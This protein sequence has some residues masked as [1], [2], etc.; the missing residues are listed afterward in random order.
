MADIPTLQ[1]TLD[2]LRTAHEQSQKELKLDERLERLE[3]QRREFEKQ[4]RLLEEQKKQNDRMI[5]ET[6]RQKEGSGIRQLNEFLQNNVPTE[7]SLIGIVTDAIQ[8]LCPQLQEKLPVCCVCKLQFGLDEILKSLGVEVMEVEQVQNRVRFECQ[9]DVCARCCA[10]MVFL[11]GRTNARNHL[12]LQ[13]PMCRQVSS[14]EKILMGCNGD[15]D[16]I[17]E[18]C[19]DS[20]DHSISECDDNESDVDILDDLGP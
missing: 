5:R 7:S 16:T 4:E 18:I 3:K 13:C 8:T 12:T 9:H 6:T 15:E 20:Y 17:R 11:S 19:I 2:K 10:T 14:C 1:K